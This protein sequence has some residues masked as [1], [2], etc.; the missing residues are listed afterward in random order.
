MKRIKI[1]A[2][3]ITNNNTNMWVEE[4]YDE[5]GIN[6]GLFLIE[7]RRGKRIQEE[8]MPS[9]CTAMHIINNA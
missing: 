1:I 7:E 9:L 6:Q 2:S 4:R 5:T 3:K 8:E